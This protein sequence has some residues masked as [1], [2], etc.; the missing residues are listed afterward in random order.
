MAD[1]AIILCLT[2]IVPLVVVLHFIT[3]WKQSREFSGDDE[4]MLEDMYVKS[5]R[6]EERITTLEKILDDELPD[7]RKKT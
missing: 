7:W 1:L 5:Q 4:K 6:M 3:K 2:I